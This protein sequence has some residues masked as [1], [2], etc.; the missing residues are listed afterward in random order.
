MPRPTAQCATLNIELQKRTPSRHRGNYYACGHC[1]LRTNNPELRVERGERE[2][3]RERERE[4]GRERERIEN[5]CFPRI[6]P[7]ATI[8]K[9]RQIYP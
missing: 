5:M 4:G 2:R 6:V 7:R 8:A 9:V 1:E 3:E